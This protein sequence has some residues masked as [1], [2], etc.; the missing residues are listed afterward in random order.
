[1]TKTAKRT[2]DTPHPIWTRDNAK[3]TPASSPV[4]VV[5]PINDSHPYADDYDPRFMFSMTKTGML[6]AAVRG[7]IN[8]AQ[9]VKDELA[10]RGLNWKGEWIGFE[11]AKSLAK[12]S[13]VRIKGKLRA[14]SIPE[15]D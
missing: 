11:D 2:V 15:N 6:V 3:A 4:F 9:L 10:N 1:M 13:P 7:E 5:E 14:V 12:C 8:I